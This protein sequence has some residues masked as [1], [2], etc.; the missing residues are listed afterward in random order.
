MTRTVRAPYRFVP[1]TPPELVVHDEIAPCPYLE[2]RLARLPL[3]IPARPLLAHE[4]D[5]RLAVGDRR[6]GLLF[7]R[8]ECPACRACEPIR[9]DATVFRPGKTLRRTVRRND[10]F[11]ELE[12]GRPVVDGTRIALYNRHKVGRGLDNGREPIDFQGYREFLGLTSCDTFEMRYR[13]R[14]VLV[15]ISIVD[16]GKDALSAVYSF[17]DP[18]HAR[19]SLGSYFIMKQLELCRTWNMRY[20]Y[21]GLYIAESEHMRYKARFLP[22]ERLLD[23]RWTEIRE[24]PTR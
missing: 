23:G 21:L 16:R 12:L 17:Y 7:Y 24:N 8:T 20:L 1:D 14:G 9:I 2:G 6:Q 19:L 11:I 4:L 10:A 15:G 5:A 18:D 3:R 22:H 13:L